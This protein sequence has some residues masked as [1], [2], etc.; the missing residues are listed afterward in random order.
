MNLEIDPARRAELAAAL[1]GPLLDAYR[2]WAGQETTR[3]VLTIVAD[4]VMPELSNPTERAT[5]SEVVAKLTARETLDKFIDVLFRLDEYA[6][7]VQD[8]PL[9]E[10][11]Y[12]AKPPSKKKPEEQ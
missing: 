9:P 12:G 11:T 8:K 5:H 7:V 1:R 4:V 10:S 3:K 2:Q 6:G